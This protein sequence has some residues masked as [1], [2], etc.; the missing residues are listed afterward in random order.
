MIN[1]LNNFDWVKLETM[2]IDEAT[3]L[4]IKT[5]Q[6]SLDQFAPEKNVR[7]QYKNIIRQ[8]WM[9]PA[10][11][12]SA[13]TRDKL[14][15]KCMAKQKSS[16]LYIDFINYR[17]LYNK[18]KNIAKQNYYLAELS[19]YQRDIRN[20]W[21][22]LNT[23]IGKQRDKSGISEMFKINNANIKDPKTIANSFCEYFSEIGNK[24]ASN[25]PMADKP[26][27][28][29]LKARSN[30]NSFFMAPIDPIEISRIIASL[31]PKNSSGHDGI[32]SKLLI[33][34]N[35]SLST[36]ICTIINKSLLAGVV[37]RMMKIARVTPIY[38]S[39]DKT[40]MGNYR[41]ISLLPSISKILEKVVH[42]RLYKFLT[43]NDILYENQYGFRPNRSTTDAVSMF[44]SHIMTALE[45]KTTTMAVLL[46]L[47]KAFDTIDHGILLKKLSHYGVR[48]IALEWFR[49]Y[50]TNRS[51]FVSYRDVE[52]TNHNV[53][54]GIPQGS[55]LGP[56]LFIIYSNDLP[57][58]L[59]HSKCI[60]FADDTTVYHSEKDINVLRSQ[61]END[62]SVLN[63]WFYANKLSLNIQKTH[64][65]LF[66]YGGTQN[67]LHDISNIALGAH[68]INR[69]NCAKFLGLY[70][71]DKLTWGDHIDHVAKK[72]ASG[73][74]ALNNVKRSLSV[75][76]LKLLYHSLVHSHLTYGT[77]LW[78]SAYQY[79]LHKLEITQKKC[80]R[81]ICG[82]PYNE[83]T[84]PLFKKLGILKLKDIYK[85]QLCKF[86]YSYTHGKLPTPL[87]A[88]F[89]TNADFHNYNTRQRYDP[90]FV[91]RKSYKLSK[92]F[93]HQGPK[94]WLEIPL[95][96][97]IAKSVYSFSYQF[98]KYVIGFY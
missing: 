2:N 19:K 63:D 98:K 26:F 89:S 28:Y 72:I 22:L 11:L 20:T 15:R 62:L 12:N 56:L 65:M 58:S 21:K 75:A 25:I 49:N 50:L 96:I 74:Y 44:T 97:R 29:Y 92:T 83:H 37:P 41:P 57:N 33:C 47:S 16:K 5:I 9:T 93:I 38:K 4:L 36:P 80:I 59:I 46:D 10:L 70:I 88:I 27:H 13:K 24:Y 81:H 78:G 18:L 86:M 3:E 42:N 55:V 17:N 7:I 95:N 30:S 1:Y 85:I 69:V 73:S 51:Q 43:I 23:M 60:L 71:D 53:T 6:F 14:H 76:N 8:S 79:K 66:Q 45:T 67:A 39:K 32:S 90:H 40:N 64:F 52:S 68:H 91:D 82:V 77:A 48:G 61:I 87:L 31:E 84:N 94:F 35:P 34:L 54:C